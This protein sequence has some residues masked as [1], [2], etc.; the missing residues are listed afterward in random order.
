MPSPELAFDDSALVE[1]TEWLLRLVATGQYDHDRGELLLGALL[2]MTID[3]D[4]LS[5]NRGNRSPVL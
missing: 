3:G 1:R 4:G 5:L 2:P